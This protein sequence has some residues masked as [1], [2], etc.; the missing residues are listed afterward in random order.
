[1]TA[2][3]SKVCLITGAGSGIGRAT[4]QLFAREGALVHAVDVDPDGLATTVD[5]IRS[6]GGR[7]RGHQVDCGDPA[8]MEALSQAVLAE[9]EQLDILINNAGWCVAGPL[10]R[11]SL[12]DWHRAV[13]VNLLGAVYGVHFFAP[14]MLAAGRGSIINVASAAGLIGFPFLGPYASTKFALV[15]LSESMDAELGARGVRVTAV[16]PGAVRTGVV[17]HGRFDLPGD[18]TQRVAQLIERSAVSPDRI[19]RDILA[20]VHRPRGLE[21]RL[22]AG[23]RAAWWIKRLAPE[24]YASLARRLTRR[25]LTK[26]EATVNQRTS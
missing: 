8:A 9:H 1:M 13:D 3:D 21:A 14:G 26:A 19:A 11:L 24:L 4:A 16:C 18:W 6:D 22:G 15:G 7:A 2:L 12:D 23:M 25:A 17:R 5:A 20:V 10:E